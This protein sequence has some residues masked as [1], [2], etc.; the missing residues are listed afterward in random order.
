[1]Q[2]RRSYRTNLN[3]YKSVTLPKLLQIGLYK[4]C[5]KRFSMKQIILI[6]T[7]G[8]YRAFFELKFHIQNLETR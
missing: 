5:R 6:W 1:M 3:H 4:P 2:F 8:K 7:L